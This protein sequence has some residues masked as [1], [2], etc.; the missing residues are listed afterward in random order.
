MYRSK[1][2]SETIAVAGAASTFGGT[3]VGVC[4]WPVTIEVPSALVLCMLLGI[5][6]AWARGRMPVAVVC[7]ASLAM[8]PVFAEGLPV[9]TG[10]SAAAKLA[11]APCTGR[12]EAATCAAAVC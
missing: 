4:V 7:A 1:G 10:T 12:P 9:T 6:V 2:I 11:Q 3:V 8:I 5:E